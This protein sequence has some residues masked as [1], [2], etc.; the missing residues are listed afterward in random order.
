MYQVRAVRWMLESFPPHAFPF[1]PIFSVGGV[2][3]HYHA[4]GRYFFQGIYGA[5]SGGAHTVLA[6]SEEYLWLSPIQ[7]RFSN[8][9]FCI[10][11]DYA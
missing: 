5:T 8:P 3:E 1:F 9:P 4:G 10:P 7:K 11:E 2:V 6:H